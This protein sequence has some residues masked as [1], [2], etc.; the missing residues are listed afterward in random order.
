[1]PDDFELGGE[2]EMDP[3]STWP[4]QRHY[5][6]HEARIAEQASICVY[7]AYTYLIF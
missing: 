6:L 2:E 3:T 4:F 5:V 7:E 1:M